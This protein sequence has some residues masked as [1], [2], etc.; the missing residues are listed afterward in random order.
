MKIATKKDWETEYLSPTISV[1]ECKWSRRG[2]RS[3]K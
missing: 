3:H 2:C 1:K